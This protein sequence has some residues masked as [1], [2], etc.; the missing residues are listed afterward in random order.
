MTDPQN[1][2][3][4]IEA[5]KAGDRDS[6]R[7]LFERYKD[8]VYRIALHYCGEESA[9]SDI[10]QQ[11]FL[12][13]F[14]TITQFRGGSE[15]STWLYRVVVNTCIDERRKVR[16]FVPLADGFEISDARIPEAKGGASASAGGFD[17]RAG[18]SQER[19]YMQKQIANAVQEAITQLSPKL[20]MPILLKYVE[21][22]S[23]EEIAEVLGISMG[24]VASRLN[25]G[26]KAL[27]G[28][29]GHLRD[30]VTTYG[31]AE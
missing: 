24:T 12:K 2:Y 28:K 23:Y 21:D 27:A 17:L 10:T 7:Q 1:E 4:I 19:K 13:L 30:S 15:F 5:C 14:T 9:A 26:H 20:R 22:L 29:L 25:R 18:G 6:F 16:R 31:S 3:P 11:V 8:R